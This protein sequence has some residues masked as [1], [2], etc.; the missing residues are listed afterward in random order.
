MQTH[1]DIIA[2]SFPPPEFIFAQAVAKKLG[3]L[4]FQDPVKMAEA[5]ALIWPEKKKWEKIAS[6]IGDTSENAQ[7]QLKL[8]SQRRN[9]IVHESDMDPL[10]NQKSRITATEAN[11]AC[12]FIGRCGQAIT[13]LIT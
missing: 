8:I 13:A 1:V 5:L 7:R 6:E 11:N 3:Y 2:A 9:S 4:S 10:T 12:D